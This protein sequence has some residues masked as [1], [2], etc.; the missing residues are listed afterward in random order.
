MT[1][2]ARRI[3]AVEEGRL[4][5]GVASERA[6]DAGGIDLATGFGGEIPI[7]ADMVGVGVGI[8]DSRERPR[9]CAEVALDLFARFLI[10]AAVDYGDGG[11]GELD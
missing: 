6:F 4:E 3:A 1:K 8:I 10:V 9:I 2:L 5:D 7:A 11:I